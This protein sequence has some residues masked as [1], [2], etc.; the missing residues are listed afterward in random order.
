MNSSNELMFTILCIR[1]KIKLIAP[2]CTKSRLYTNNIKT[3]D[4]IN[5]ITIAECIKILDDTMTCDTT[6]PYDANDT[7]MYVRNK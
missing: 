7:V 1:R 2:F 5:A 4:D 6:N 3:D